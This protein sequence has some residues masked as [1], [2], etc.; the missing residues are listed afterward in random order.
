MSHAFAWLEP[1]RVIRL[2]VPVAH[3]IVQHDAGVA[4]HRR[5]EEVVDALNAGDGVA[6]A[7]DHAEVGRVGAGWDRAGNRP[8]RGA[9]RV[10]LSGQL[11]GVPF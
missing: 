6:L 10:D 11:A 7:V 8:L 4:G 5:A 1:V 2:E 9:A 3:P